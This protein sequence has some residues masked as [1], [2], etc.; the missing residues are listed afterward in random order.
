MSCE[1]RDCKYW[2]FNKAGYH[3]CDYLL[4]T[5]HTRDC[6]IDNCDKYDSRSKKQPG[7]K[8]YARLD[9]AHHIDR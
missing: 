2:C 9:L 4:R 6:D 1:K 7:W 3:T 8:S 5:G